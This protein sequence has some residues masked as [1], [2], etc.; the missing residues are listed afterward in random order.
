MIFHISV[1]KNYKERAHAQSVKTEI[2]WKE[3]K[4]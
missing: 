1:E 2:A 4:F 3:R